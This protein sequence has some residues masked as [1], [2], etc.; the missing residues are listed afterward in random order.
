MNPFLKLVCVT[1]VLSVW[2]CSDVKL[3][4]QEQGGAD[5]HAGAYLFEWD[6]G[7][8]K[9]TAGLRD[10]MRTLIFSDHANCPLKAVLM[11]SGS[12]PSCGESYFSGDGFG[13]CI[14]RI[15]SNGQGRFVELPSMKKGTF[16]SL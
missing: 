5:L 6:D 14:S 11:T 12:H 8:G 13:F 9:C 2:A 4:G 7:T 15:I 10:G 16:T 1:V 3:G